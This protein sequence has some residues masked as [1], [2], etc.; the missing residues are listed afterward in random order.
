MMEVAQV[1][2]FVLLSQS[3]DHKGKLYNH[4]FFKLIGLAV[5]PSLSQNCLIICSF[6]VTVWTKNPTPPLYFVNI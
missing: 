3:V 4:F 6:T 2:K 5:N 1:A